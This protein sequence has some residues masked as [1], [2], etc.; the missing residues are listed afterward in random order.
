[1]HVKEHALP[2]QVA[3]TAL[4]GTGH[5]AQLV[6]QALMSS[7]LGHDC[8]H[9]WVSAGQVEP[10]ALAASMHAPRH[11]FLPEGQVPSHFMPLHVAVPPFAGAWHGEHDVAQVCGLSFATHPTGQ[12]CWFSGHAGGGSP[13]S[14]VPSVATSAS[15]PSGRST[16]PSPDAPAPPSAPDLPAAPE[17]RSVP[18]SR[19]TQRSALHTSGEGHLPVFEHGIAPEEIGKSRQP[20]I[21]PSKSTA[22]KTS[23]AR[24]RSSL[25]QPR[26]RGRQ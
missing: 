9:R 3:D 26:S 21:D 1:L 2:S 7:V 22:E 5:G 23:P 20:T 17:A 24:I 16:P 8:P 4:A 12:R 6:P 18:A 13:V 25:P 10:Q 14:G 15:A 11:S 19:A